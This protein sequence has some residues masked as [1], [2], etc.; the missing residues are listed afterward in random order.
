MG[1][2]VSQ[3]RLAAISQLV[4][5][6]VSVGAKAL[7]GGARLEGK[8]YFYAPT[9]LADAPPSAAI[10]RDE[11]FGPVLTLNRFDS[12]ADAIGQANAVAY[13]L[14]AY[15]FTRDAATA[16]LLSARLQCGMVGINHFVVSTDG[17][18]FGGVKDSGFGREGG[19]E[20]ILNYTIAK[21]IS[22]LHG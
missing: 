21:T 5:Q 16:H 3:R 9:I 12:L 4:D 18:P 19:T 6:A 7:V 8:G 11:P 14:A 10:L 17:M 20:G 22:H 15:V 2:L 1:P 13:G